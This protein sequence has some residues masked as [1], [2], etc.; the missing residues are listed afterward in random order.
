MSEEMPAFV[1]VGLRRRGVA[2]R[3][4]LRWERSPRTCAAV[5]R[6]LPV[7]DQVWHAKYAHNEVYALVPAWEADPPLEWACAYPGPGDLMYIP[8][9]PGLLPGGEA[10]RLVDLAYFYE[11]GNNLYGPFG[12][13]IGSIFA[14][15]TSVEEVEAMAAACQDVWFAGARDEQLVIE[16]A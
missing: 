14:T 11:R 9:P 8:H 13:A 3:L 7:A 1:R 5:C 6:R 4:K 15:M 10:G 2:V 12:P 16:P